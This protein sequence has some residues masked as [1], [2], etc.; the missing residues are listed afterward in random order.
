[1]TSSSR[2]RV[3]TVGNKRKDPKLFYSNKF[4]SH[5]HERHFQTVQDRRL[6]MERKVRWILSL[7]PHFGEEIERRKWENV[8]AYPKPA[9]IAVVKEFYT[10]A[11][12]FG[13]THTE[14]YMSYV[15]GNIIRYDPDTINRFLHTEWASEQCQFA[16]SMDEGADFDD[17]ERT[18]AIFLYCMLKGLNINI[19]QVIAYEIQTC[20]SFV[21][22]KA[23]LGHPSLITHLC[24]LAGVNTSTSPMERPRK[25][26][27]DSYYS[28]YCMMDEATQQVPPPHPPQVHK[29][30]P[31]PTHEHSQ[32]AQPF[33]M[34]DMYM[35]LM[36]SRMQ[37]LHGGQVATV[38]MIIGLYDTPPSWQSTMDEFNTVVG[39]PEDQ[40]HASGAGAAEASTIEDDD[41]DDE[42]KDGDEEEE[43]DDEEEDSD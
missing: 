43:D 24:E 16:L 23:S 7:A 36:E 18:L 20:V 8:A 40:A 2:K 10:N 22:N 4:L 39:W 6:L 19:G 25:E 5:K 29:R 17:V 1:M 26:I 38:E 37:A 35:S 34:R 31:P 42:Y 30:G 32:D 12:A 11:R 15:R 3:K 13:N 21:N 14:N 33:Q 27:D 28:Q 9:N 41:E